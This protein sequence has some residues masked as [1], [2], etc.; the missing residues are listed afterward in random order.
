MPIPILQTDMKMDMNY[1]IFINKDTLRAFFETSKVMFYFCSV[2]KNVCYFQFEK[3]S[4]IDSSTSVS[5][6]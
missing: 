2:L 6:L 5:L 3:Q 4:F 1:L